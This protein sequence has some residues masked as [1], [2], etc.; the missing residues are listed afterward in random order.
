MILPT[1][2]PNFWPDPI[3]IW[4]TKGDSETKVFFMDPSKNALI[5]FAWSFPASCYTQSQLPCFFLGGGSTCSGLKDHEKIS[6]MDVCFMRRKRVGP[7]N[8]VS[9][10]YDSNCRLKPFP[11]E[12]IFQHLKEYVRKAKHSKGYLGFLVAFAFNPIVCR[13]KD[14]FEP[15]I[16]TVGF[17]QPKF[18]PPFWSKNW[19][20][21]LQ[22]PAL[23]T[24]SP[25]IGWFVFP[26]AIQ[27]LLTYNHLEDS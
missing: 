11:L 27:A 19:W 10:M 26:S 8:S 23:P 3:F 15:K 6:N 24:F 2:S 5:V 9:E 20:V 1:R 7:H 17:L 14:L 18:T 16:G 13:V 25:R 4:K 21:F 12:S 22:L